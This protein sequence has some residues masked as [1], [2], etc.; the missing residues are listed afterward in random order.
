METHHGITLRHYSPRLSDEDILTLAKAITRIEARP[1]GNAFGK[2]IGNFI[3]RE[4]ERRQ[5]NEIA[6]PPIESTPPVFNAARWTDG[7]LADA[8]QA[9]R[10]LI[11]AVVE[12]PECHE[13]ASQIHR[14]ICAWAAT[15]LRSKNAG[16]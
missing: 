9:S 8:L 6:D 14:I 5:A 3:D 10:V 7:E 12:R 13:F 16:G 15:R 4:I 2:W 1:I 11:D